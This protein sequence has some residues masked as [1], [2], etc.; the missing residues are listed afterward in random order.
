MEGKKHSQQHVPRHGGGERKDGVAVDMRKGVQGLVVGALDPARLGIW[1]APMGSR[2]AAEVR[3]A[4]S[5]RL[6]FVSSTAEGG[7][8]AARDPTSALTGSDVKFQAL[9]EAVL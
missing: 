8:E 4:G 3:V 9:E 6:R 5:D 2:D 7:A 1:T